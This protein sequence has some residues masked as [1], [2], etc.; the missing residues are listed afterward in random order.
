MIKKGRPYSNENGALGIALLS[1]NP[2]CRWA[3]KYKGE[4]SPR[5]DF[6]KDMIDCF[7]FPIFAEHSIIE[8][9]L[10]WKGAC[11]G[12]LEAFEE[13]WEEYS[14]ENNTQ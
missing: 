5:G 3:I 14:K 7:D 6:V 10:F 12:A 2:F 8:R 11:E 9:Y 1:D 4:N 13:L